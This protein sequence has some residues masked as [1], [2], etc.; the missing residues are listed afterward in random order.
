MR[1]EEVKVIGK[2]QVKSSALFMKQAKAQS[3]SPVGTVAVRTKSDHLDTWLL[4]H[5]TI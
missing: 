5:G 3:S 4:V 1:R 2:L